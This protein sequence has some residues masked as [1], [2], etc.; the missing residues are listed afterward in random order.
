MLCSQLRDKGFGYHHF[1]CQASPQ[2]SESE[3]R[4]AATST[5]FRPLQCQEDMSSCAQVLLKNC[6]KLQRVVIA[7]RS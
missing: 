5:A 3:P 1:S 6:A 2:R 4:L 7:S